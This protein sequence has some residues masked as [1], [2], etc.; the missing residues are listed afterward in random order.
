MAALYPKR[1]ASYT[2]LGDTI[3]AEGRRPEKSRIRAA[4]SRP[5]RK[6]TRLGR[7]AVRRALDLDVFVAPYTH[8]ICRDNLIGM[9][10]ATA[11]NVH[12]RRAALKSAT[13]KSNM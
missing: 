6:A 12:D 13:P 10:A 4:R 9:S 2:T 1:P 5:Q 8:I 11:A 3:C 7:A